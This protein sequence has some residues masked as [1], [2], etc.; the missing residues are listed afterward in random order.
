[1]RKVRGK[2][3]SSSMHNFLG[4]CGEEVARYV[5][6]SGQRNGVSC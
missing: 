1:M 5:S 6:T 3:R 4:V 2:D